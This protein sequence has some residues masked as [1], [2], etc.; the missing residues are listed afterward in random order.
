[1]SVGKE[2]LPGNGGSLRNGGSL[3]KLGLPKRWVSQF[4]EQHRVPQLVFLKFVELAIKFFIV[5]FFERNIIIKL[6]F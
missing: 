3:G 5:K 1:M 6:L 4:H 2:G